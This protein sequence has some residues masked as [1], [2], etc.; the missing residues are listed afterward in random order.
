MSFMHIF[1][2]KSEVGRF[3]HCQEERHVARTHLKREYFQV[4]L[5]RRHSRPAELI[6][7]RQAPS[8]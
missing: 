8:G 6:G 2:S 3:D 5:E 7:Q 4:C 1:F